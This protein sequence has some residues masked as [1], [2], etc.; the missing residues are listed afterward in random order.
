[1]RKRGSDGR[2][3]AVIAVAAMGGK[4]LFGVAGLSANY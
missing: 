2:L 4:Q 1:M 3:E